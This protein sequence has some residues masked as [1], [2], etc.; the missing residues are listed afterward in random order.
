[1]AN[2][3]LA[4]MGGGWGMAGGTAFLTAA[5]AALGGYQGGAISNAY[6]GTIQ[7]FEITKVREG[8]GP[9]VICLNGFLTEGDHNTRDWRDGL[10]PHFKHNPMYHVAWES[11][12]LRAVGDA[13][14][15]ATRDAAVRTVVANLSKR[16]SRKA[17]NPLT[18]GTLFTGVARNPW[19]VALAKAA[20][21]GILLADL[22]ART[23]HRSGFILV[24]HSLGARAILYALQ[25]LSTKPRKVVKDAYLLGGAVDAEPKSWR[26][27]ASAV[28]GTIYNCYSRND[29]ILRH[30]Y[31]CSMLSKEEP[32]GIRP[33]RVP[34]G[35]IRNLD[36]SSFVPGHTEFKRALPAILEWAHTGRK[37]KPVS[38]DTT[39]PHCKEELALKAIPMLE[40]EFACAACEEPFLFR[41]D[42]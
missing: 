25:S 30:L 28:S 37:P 41:A 16:A 10:R 11:K 12:N 39:C 5:G 26:A 6:Y 7:G 8:R 17:I 1:M 9:A 42:A 20:Q 27:A 35:N 29:L 19:H 36:V 2:A 31:R 13:F 23:K 21:T 33:I 15:G 22:L 40:E 32:A 3:A 24:G 18:W 34:G 14:K 38:Y 4:A